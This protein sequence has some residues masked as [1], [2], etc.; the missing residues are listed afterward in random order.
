MI[1]ETHLMAALLFG[2]LGIQWGVL[3]PSAVFVFG[4]FF[5]ALLPDIDYSRSKIG[6]KVRP[7]SNLL[8]FLTGHRGCVHSFTAMLLLS[9]PIGAL[10]V[11]VGADMLRPFLVGYLSHL[12]MDSL[13]PK[14]IKPLF[15]LAY[16]VRGPI[17][18]GTWA[19]RLIFTFF[20]IL[21]MI[22]AYV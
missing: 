17:K 10:G 22:L 9:I 14:G 11:A 16:R 1:W 15:P 19:E 4:L 7:F 3:E 8:E 13:T 12:A 18:T 21:A 20:L 2:M 5:G 6:W